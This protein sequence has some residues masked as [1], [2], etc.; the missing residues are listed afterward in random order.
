MAKVVNLYDAK[1]HLSELVEQAAEGEEIIIAK[2][3][4]PMAKLAPVG[5]AGRKR[6][7]KLGQ[8]AEHA[9]GTD[10]TAWWRDWKAADEDI[11]AEFAAAAA[12]PFP[13]A[14]RKGRRR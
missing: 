12:R 2:A 8:L 11:A 9:K 3:G 13:A 6:P 4:K 10:W 14:R 7:R 1:T 5:S